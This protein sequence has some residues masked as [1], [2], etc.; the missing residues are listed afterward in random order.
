MI[1]NQSFANSKATLY[2]VAT[3]IGN[4][5]DITFRAVE[6]LKNVDYILAEDTRV[7]GTLLFHYSIKTKMISYHKFNEKQKVQ[8]VLNLLK[9]GKNL[10]LVSDAGTPIICDPGYNLV[11]EIFENGYNVV[12]IPGACAYINGL[13]C[14]GFDA[15]DVHFLGFMPKKQGEIINTLKMH[16][17]SKSTLIFY[18]SPK[19]I[20]KTFEGF[21]ENLPA[22]N[23]CLCN[24]LTKK[25][26]KI[27]RGSPD[28]ILHELRENTSAEKG[29]YTIV[30]ETETETN[31][32]DFICEEKISLESII[33]DVMIKEKC[34]VKDAVKYIA[35]D[36]THDFGKN[37]VYTASLNLK[38]MFGRDT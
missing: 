29:E 5:A 16:E 23:F 18:E 32:D 36:K 19:R 2:L 3:P 34:T 1:V 22:A 4:L 31:A 27:Y 8:E 28:K 6:I 17:N 14:S 24:D 9:K 37:E 7:T 10:A 12:S 33:V 38:K 15:T 30:I 20:I 21:T 11:K 35:N 26:E 13:I 25:F